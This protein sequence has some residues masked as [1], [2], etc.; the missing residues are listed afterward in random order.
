MKKIF[1]AF[2]I[3]AI[4]LII[5]T[6]FVAC[7]KDFYTIESNVLGQE[8]A[9]FVTDFKEY[10]IS[11]YNKRLNGIQINNL[12][13]NLLGFF[14]DPDF[15]TTT[16]SIVADIVPSSFSS[17]STPNIFGDN[18]VIDSVILNIPYFN[19]VTGFDENGNNTYTISDSLYVKPVNEDAKNNPDPIKISIYENGYFINTAN[20][21][22]VGEGQNYFSY[23]NNG[24]TDNYAQTETN[25]INF[26]DL[27]GVLISEIDTTFSPEPVKTGMGEDVVRTD[28]ALRL[29]LDNEDGDYDFWTNKL[30]DKNGQPELSNS[31][32][33]KNYFRGLYIKAEAIN[34]KGSMVM[35]NLASTDAEITIHY[36]K[37]DGDGG[38]ES[39]EYALRFSDQRL[40]T[41][42]NNYTA[43]LEN[44]DAENGDEIIYLKG[45]EGS[46]AIIDLFPTSED[47]TN[48]LK[49]YR[50]EDGNG[51]YLKDE[52]TGDYILKKLINEAHLEIYEK[53]D[54]ITV[55]NTDFHKYDR[56]YTYDLE[57]NTPPLDYFSDG[58]D[59][60]TIPVFSK[61]FHSTVRNSET[62][63]YKIRLTQHLNNILI[64]GATNTQIGLTLSSN[65]NITSNL[66]TLDDINGISEEFRVTNVPATS[67]IAPRG[68]ILYGS[69]SS[70]EKHLKFKVFSTEPK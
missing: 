13:S 4:V 39:A 65:I 61:V 28:P 26:D 66:E 48:F 20:S 45:I 8:N 68:T 18:P 15:G 9:N 6:S 47:L 51:D 40:N 32:I 55:T 22:N 41:F 11:A 53:E 49:E 38:R 43:P 36:T 69:N 25:I 52:I 21:G 67:L 17:S 60:L 5:I 33:F 14:D 29:K 63:A 31:D 7:D 50:I 24:S 62:G 56:L 57:N 12:P 70:S 10:K 46:M 58:T 34:N 19:R 1:E 42:I 35:L 54:L 44:G 23:S 27:K 37:D 30:L 59:N 64:N 3:P 2:R 16:A